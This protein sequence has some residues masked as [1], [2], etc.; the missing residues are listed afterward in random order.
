M[1][2]NKIIHQLPLEP[3]DPLELCDGVPEVLDELDTLL[4]AGAD[5]FAPKEVSIIAAIE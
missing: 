2:L 3:V 4:E 1:N 5:K